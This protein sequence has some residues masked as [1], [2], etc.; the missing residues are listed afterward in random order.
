MFKFIIN[1]K[2]CKFIFAHED[3]MVVSGKFH[4]IAA[5][6]LGKKFTVSIRYK[7]RWA[8]QLTW[9]KRKREKSDCRPPQILRRPANSPVRNK[10]GLFH[11]RSAQ[12]GCGAPKPPVNSYGIGEVGGGV[13][14]TGVLTPPSNA[15]GKNAQSCT[16]ILPT[17]H[18][19]GASQ[20]FSVPD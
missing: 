13:L 16:S 15:E 19:D 7:A 17:C 3:K 6:P 5:L 20:A 10:S 1:L 4:T 8:S 18:T 9:I 14:N 11:F 12:T 2:Q